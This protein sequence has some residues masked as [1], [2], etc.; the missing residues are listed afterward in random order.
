MT[1]VIDRFVAGRGSDDRLIARITFDILGTAAIEEF[2]VGAPR[3]WPSACA[4][5]AP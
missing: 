1:H 4:R 2:E 5:A 3:H